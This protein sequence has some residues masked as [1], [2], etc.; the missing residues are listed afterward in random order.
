MLTNGETE[1]KH[2]LANHHLLKEKTHL[3][4]VS[5]EPTKA[6]MLIFGVYLQLHFDDTFLNGTEKK[7]YFSNSNP[8][9]KTSLL[10]LCCWQCNHAD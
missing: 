4:A 5:I 3:T 10:H 6:T 9:C 8:P 1:N 7:N 2:F